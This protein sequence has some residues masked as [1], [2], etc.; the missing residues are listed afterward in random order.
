MLTLGFK[1]KTRRLKKRYV[2]ILLASNRKKSQL[3]R[4]SLFTV[5]GVTGI[6]TTFPGYNPKKGIML[7]GIVFSKVQYQDGRWF[8]IQY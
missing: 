4:R 1:D 6:R 2:I 7:F 5:R 3:N 8:T